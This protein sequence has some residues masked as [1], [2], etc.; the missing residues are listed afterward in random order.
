MIIDSHLHLLPV[1][2]FSNFNEN[3][4]K[5]FLEMDKNRIDYAIVIPDNVPGSKIG[6]LDTLL[7]LMKDEK[8]IFLVGT[9]NLDFDIKKQIEKLEKLFIKEK[10]K[11][12][13]IFPGHDPIYPNDK[14]LFPLYRICIKYNLPLVIHTGINSNDS[15]CSKYND[16]EYIVAIAK[17]FPSLKIIIAHYFWPKVEY[18]YKITR[19]YNNIY[20]D[21]SALADEEVLLKTGKENIKKVLEQSIKYNYKSVLFGSDYSMCSI[22]EHIKLINSLKITKKERERVLYKNANEIFRLNVC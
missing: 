11:G 16:P 5:L 20:F 1:K 18:C 21:T 9:I 7:E 13:K 8:R 4:K 12:V 19:G 10:I 14:R 17:K 3:K 6:D 15:A 22:K 2:D